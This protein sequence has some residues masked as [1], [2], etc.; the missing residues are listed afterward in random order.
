[1]ELDR[2]L[3]APDPAAPPSLA[4]ASAMS[5][6]ALRRKWERTSQHIIKEAQGKVSLERPGQ[7]APEALRRPTRVE[8]APG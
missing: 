5:D 7:V 1:M 2:L 8:P 6:E 3:S 4:L